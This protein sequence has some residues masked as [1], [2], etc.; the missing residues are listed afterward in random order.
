MITGNIY[1]QGEDYYLLWDFTSIDEQRALRRLLK[2]TET[3]IGYR[4]THF[5]TKVQPLAGQMTID[6]Y[7]V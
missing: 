3:R 5:I 6:C 1:K 4:V 7:G 2:S